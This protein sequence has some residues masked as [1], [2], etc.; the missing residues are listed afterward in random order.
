[1]LVDAEQDRRRRRASVIAGVAPVPGHW[2]ALGRLRAPARPLPA[3]AAPQRRAGAAPLRRQRRAGD[4][5]EPITMPFG[6]LTVS[7]GKHRRAGSK[8]E[9]D[10]VTAGE[11][12]A[13]IET[14][15]AVV[16]I[17]APVA[18]RLG[19]S[20]S[21]QGAVVP[22]GGR[23]GWS[24]RADPPEW[25]HPGYPIRGAPS[26]EGGPGWAAQRCPE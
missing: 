6:D 26:A 20:S 2:R 9:G 3:A 23:I 18:G 4:E 16:E 15:K 12:V 11:L 24:A 10:A 13:E 8:A 1:M 25:R 22:M 17:E 14:D 21:R 19:R 5:G 7:E